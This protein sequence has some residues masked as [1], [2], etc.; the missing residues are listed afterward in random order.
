MEVGDTLYC[1]KDFR[2]EEGVEFFVCKKADKAKI[3]SFYDKGSKGCNIDI[4][5]NR[6]W[7]I[8]KRT[9]DTNKSLADLSEY[10]ET[11]IGRGNRIINEFKKR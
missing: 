6:T 8:T 4:G 5:D 1:K 3:I 11:K 9:R 10:F 7:F 2:S